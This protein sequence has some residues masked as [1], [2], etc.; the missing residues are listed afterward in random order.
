MRLLLAISAI[1]F[2]KVLYGQDIDKQK[3]AIDAEVERISKQ[4][5]LKTERFSI[6]ALKKVLHYIDYQYVENTKGYVNIS[7]Q[8]SHQNDSVQQTFCLKD[9]KLIHAT[10]V[11]TSYFNDKDKRDSIAW[12]GSFYFAKGRLID[13]ITLGHG[14]SELD[15]WNPEQD[16]VTALSD[17]KRDIARYKKKKKEADN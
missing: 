13:H 15:T 14:K 3:A 6:Q 1:L 8:F 4:S 16:M 12:S 2:S 5:K 7:R 10:E 11:I 17:A 9:G